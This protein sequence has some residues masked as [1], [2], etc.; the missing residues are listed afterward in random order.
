MEKKQFTI[1]ILLAV[2]VV[3]ILGGIGLWI[4]F[5]WQSKTQETRKLDEILTEVDYALSL[6]YT[7][8]AGDLLSVAADQA[9]GERNHLRILK[10]VYQIGK[11]A[12]DIESLEIYA[13][14]ALTKLPG[15]LAIKQAYAYA[16]LRSAHYV[17]ALD[18]LGGMSKSVPLQH[19]WAEANVVMGNTIRSSDHL[20]PNLRQLIS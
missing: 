13:K 7:L 12:G 4:G 16:A 8:R 15:S 14:S 9:Y 3:S 17:E 19:L 6:G 5:R 10:R 11:L 2:I 18:V 20:Q 1:R